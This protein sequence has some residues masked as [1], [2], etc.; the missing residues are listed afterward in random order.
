MSKQGRSQ[1]LKVARSSCCLKPG[2]F[3][4]RVHFLTI[5]SF[6]LFSEF[7]EMST[8]DA[9]GIRLHSMTGKSSFGQPGMSRGEER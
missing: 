3:A 5:F 1:L 8:M 7:S 9:Y 6:P 2:Y 4:V